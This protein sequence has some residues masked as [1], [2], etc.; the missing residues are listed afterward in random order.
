M[1]PIECTLKLTREISADDLKGMMALRREA[2]YCEPEDPRY[3]H[4]GL[5]NLYDEAWIA[6]SHAK[7]ST[8]HFVLVRM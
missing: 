2:Y 1:S 5:H 4:G 8:S 6:E 7:D 3:I